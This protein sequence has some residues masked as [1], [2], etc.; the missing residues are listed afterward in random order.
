MID[1]GIQYDPFCRMQCLTA[2][3]R[4]VWMKGLIKKDF[5]WLGEKRGEVLTIPPIPSTDLFNR[6]KRI[7]REIALMAAEQSHIQE[8]LCRELAVEI[9]KELRFH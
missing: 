2:F 9:R 7:L 1:T 4:T 5:H 6:E 8:I 3:V